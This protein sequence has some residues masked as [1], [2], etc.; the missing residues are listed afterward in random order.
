MRDTYLILLLF[1]VGLLGGCSSQREVQIVREVQR[2]TLYQNRIL[3]DSVYVDNWLLTERTND[4]VYLEKA[5]V[6]YRYHLL[7]DTVRIVQSDTIP[8]PVTF[9]EVKEVARPLSGFDRLC[10][11]CFWLLCGYVGFFVYEIKKKT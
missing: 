10:R 4:T 9:T 3:Y 2:D 6:E 1:A 5:H 7:H 11:L 8:Y